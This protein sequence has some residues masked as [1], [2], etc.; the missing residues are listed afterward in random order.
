MAPGQPGGR[1][2][3]G[4]FSTTGY[5]LGWCHL[6]TQNKKGCQ[7]SCPPPPPPALPHTHITQAQ[8]HRVTL[9]RHSNTQ[10]SRNLQ[11]HTC[12]RHTTACSCSHRCIG[13]QTPV[14]ADIPKHMCKWAHSRGY[15]HTWMQDK[16]CASRQEGD[17]TLLFKKGLETLAS[18]CTNHPS[19]I[20]QN[21]L[22]SC[23]SIPS[24]GAPWSLSTGVQ[25]RSSMQAFPPRGLP[26]K[27]SGQKDFWSPGKA[28]GQTDTRE[29]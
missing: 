25:K 9:N 13:T 22:P 24:V 4:H 8:M 26:C 21:N 17:H 3:T 16:T 5:N 23:Q 7:H 10:M 20:N 18:P 19:Q 1:G 27:G 14:H 6:H 29:V 11:I 28:S 12:I 15:A 2:I